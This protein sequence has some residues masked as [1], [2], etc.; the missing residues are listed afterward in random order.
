ME[1]KYTREDLKILQSNPWERKVSIAQTRIIEFHREMNGRIFVSFSGGKDSIVLLDIVRRM[2]PETPA[3]FCNT[4][5]E[6][7][8]VVKFIKTV[9]NV[10][11]IRPE[12]P[13]KQVIDNYGFCFPNKEVSKYIDSYRRKLPYIMRRMNNLDCQEFAVL[14]LK[15]YIWLVDMPYKISDKCCE[16]M[17][18]KPFKKFSKINKLF[19]IIGSTA[20]E[21]VLRKQI[22]LRY[23]CNILSE[24]N[25]K[26]KPLSI[27]TE[28]DV[29]NYIRFYNLKIAPDY[30]EIIEEKGKL[31]L[32][33]C[34]RTGC[35]FCTVGCNNRNDNRFLILKN[36]FPKLYDYC[37]NYLKMGEM[38]DEFNKYLRPHKQII[39]K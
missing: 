8:S 4:G 17:K 15:K 19:P 34:T 28:Q 2:Y 37:I 25:P 3:V 24:K 9:P 16:I 35:V 38:F 1:D 33:K 31:K 21:S 20:E 6:S 5:L 27:F 22:W 10:I 11:T 36:D 12:M 30:G 26:S 18:K 14:D 23:G 39:Y 32:T 7:P 29:L 13:F